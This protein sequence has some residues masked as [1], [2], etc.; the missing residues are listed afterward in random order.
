MVD[1][2]RELTT[3]AETGDGC[4]LGRM[5]QNEDIT[6]DQTRR[7]LQQIDQMN[8]ADRQTNPKLPIVHLE[9]SNQNI[10]GNIIADLYITPAQNV[11]SYGRKSASQVMF[12]TF[13]YGYLCE[14]LRAPDFQFGREGDGNMWMMGD[15]K[16]PAGQRNFWGNQT[17]D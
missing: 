17:F 13:K 5:L 4:A 15:N 14:T 1:E 8:T 2:I 6:N 11:P 16:K 7:V 12:S 9:V 10:P 3:T